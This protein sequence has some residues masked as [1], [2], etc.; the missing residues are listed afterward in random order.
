IG[1][2]AAGDRQQHLQ[3]GR[4]RVAA[5]IFGERLD[6]RGPLILIAHIGAN[7]LDSEGAFCACREP[8]DAAVGL[9]VVW[10]NRHPFGTQ[11]GEGLLIRIGAVKLLVPTLGIVL[12]LLVALLGMGLRVGVGLIFGAVRCIVAQEAAEDVTT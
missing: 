2:M 8:K 12:V 6:L 10:I 4:R 7:H 11:I 9:G 1:A 3:R 5:Q